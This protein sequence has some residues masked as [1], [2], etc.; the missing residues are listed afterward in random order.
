MPASPKFE[1]TLVSRTLGAASLLTTRLRDF[2]RVEV[3]SRGECA[4]QMF[5]G[6][7][8]V[9]EEIRPAAARLRPAR[10]AADYDTLVASLAAIRATAFGNWFQLLGEWQD[11][12]LSYRVD[13]RA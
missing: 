1:A 10:F 3:G 12:L 13:L 11:R 2:L 9:V 4:R 6:I 5:N 8:A 7:Q